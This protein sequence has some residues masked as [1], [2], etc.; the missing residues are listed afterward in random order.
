MAGSD[1]ISVYDWIQF[2]DLGS[3]LKRLPCFF[4]E[5]ESVVALPQLNTC[6]NASLFIYFLLGYYL[7]SWII[8]YWKYCLYLSVCF[9]FFEFLMILTTKYYHLLN[10]TCWGVSVQH[11]QIT[12][13]WTVTISCVFLQC[14]CK[15]ETSMEVCSYNYLSKNVPKNVMAL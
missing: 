4:L 13:D 2:S 1:V 14:Y 7:I 11:L 12:T 8:I 10:F 5:H 3:L 6:W 15:V 9:L